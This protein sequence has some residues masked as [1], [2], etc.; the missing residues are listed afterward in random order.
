MLGDVAGHLCH[1]RIVTDFWDNK[2]HEN[3]TL[4]GDGTNFDGSFLADEDCWEG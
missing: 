4:I 2:C 1:R 3:Q